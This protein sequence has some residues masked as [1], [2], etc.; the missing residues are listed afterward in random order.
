MW[1]YG[2]IKER[3][4]RLQIYEEPIGGFFTETSC[5]KKSSM[6]AQKSGWS[7]RQR[8]AIFAEQIA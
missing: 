7:L 2:Q 5:R 1:L 3:R 8:E 4:K 6:M